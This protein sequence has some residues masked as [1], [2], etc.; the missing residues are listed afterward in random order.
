MS[1]AAQREGQRG[2]FAPGPEPRGGPTQTTKNFLWDYCVMTN[3][4][5][6]K[7]L[8]HQTKCVTTRTKGHSKNEKWDW[9]LVKMCD[10]GQRVI[11]K[12]SL[13]TSENLWRR[14]K[15]HSK[16]EFEPKKGHQKKYGAST[17]TVPRGLH[18]GKSGPG[19]AVGWEE[20]FAPTL[21]LIY[22]PLCYDWTTAM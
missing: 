4:G 2:Q 13:V 19:S 14:T 6:M 3:K 20:L 17:T 18:Q 8:V 9:S 7:K 1:R 22:V 5:S 16:S 21:S 11:E 10:D 12:V 15:G